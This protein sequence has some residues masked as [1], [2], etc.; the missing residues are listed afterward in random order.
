VAK[1]I[2]KAIGYDNSRTKA[3]HRLGHESSEAQAN[4]WRTFATA[5]V[6][7]DGQGYIEVRRDNALLGRMEFGPETDIFG[8]ITDVYD[9][10]PYYNR[11]A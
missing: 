9:S 10:R 6:N 3:V 5:F 7:K 11:D 2:A 4:T 1:T 8:G